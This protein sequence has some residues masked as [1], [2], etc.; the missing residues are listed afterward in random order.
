[1]QNRQ[2][3]PS[4]R[5]SGA[6][7][8]AEQIDWAYSVAVAEQIGLDPVV[9]AGQGDAALPGIGNPLTVSATAPRYDLPP[10]ALGERGKAIRAWLADP[11]APGSAGEESG[12]RAGRDTHVMR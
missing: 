9:L 1:M 4:I 6:L 8:S 12:G 11:D 7:L 5:G 3:W 10:P 2:F